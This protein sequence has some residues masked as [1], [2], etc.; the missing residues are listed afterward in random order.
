MTKL[1]KTAWFATKVGIGGGVVY[2]T[3]DQG[4]WGS[5]HQATAAYDRLFDI[6]PG[7]KSVSEKYLKLPKKEDVNINFRSYWNTGVFYTF[8][9]IANL[10]S[11]VVNLKDYVVDFAS[12]PPADGKQEQTG[13]AEESKAVPEAAA[14]PPAPEAP[15][16]QEKTTEET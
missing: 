7:T 13:K 3:V 6:M 14:P 10:P 2:L 8:D 15:A 11:K 16:A 12:S 1:L 5:S 4:I 9:F